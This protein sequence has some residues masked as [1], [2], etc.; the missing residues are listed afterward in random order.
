MHTFLALV[1]LP[2]LHA[3]KGRSTGNQLVGELALVLL[4]TV[5]LTVSFFG[6]ACM[7]G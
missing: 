3:G 6:F 4:L 7:R 2:G 1:V 5:N